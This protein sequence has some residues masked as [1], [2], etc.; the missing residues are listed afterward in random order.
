MTVLHSILYLIAHGTA[1]LALLSIAVL[2]VP[3]Q[4]QF[5]SAAGMI[6]FISMPSGAINH[7]IFQNLTRLVWK[8]REMIL[9]CFN[10]VLL[11]TAYAM[12]GWLITVVALSVFIVI[13]MCRFGQ[14]NWNYVDL[15]SKLA[16][17]VV[18]LSGRGFLLSVP[19]LFFIR[20]VLLPHTLLV[21]RL[22]KKENNQVR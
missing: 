10:C 17:C 18:Y 3:L 22:Y 19:V 16:S 11:T 8:S 20:V 13:F 7:P 4:V 5:A 21:G 9:F 15:C 2:G 6:L 1:V 14:S 12:Q